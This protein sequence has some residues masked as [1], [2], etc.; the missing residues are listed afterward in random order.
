MFFWNC[1]F[2]PNLQTYDNYRNARQESLKAVIIEA[3]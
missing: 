2:Q 1:Q 3:T